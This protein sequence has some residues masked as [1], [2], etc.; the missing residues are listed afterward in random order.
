MSSVL[1][2]AP[3][4]RARA[5]NRLLAVVFG[6]LLLVLGYFVYVKLD[7]KGQW[8]AEK[9]RPL[10]RGDVWTT[11]LIP[12]IE[13]TLRAA[14]TAGVL[15]LVLG[16]VLGLGRLSDHWWVRAPAGAVVEFFRA[17]RGRDVG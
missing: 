9:W 17:R 12:G 8:A 10:V 14:L 13:G 6:V 3:G 7:Q 15:A 1:Y 2:D 16:A 11:Y 4:P 5:R